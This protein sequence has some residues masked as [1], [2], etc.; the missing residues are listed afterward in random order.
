MK[1]WEVYV[2]GNFVMIGE[3]G[4]REE[5]NKTHYLGGLKSIARMQVD[6][7]VSGKTRTSMWRATRLA[8]EIVAS[9]NAALE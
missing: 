9:H 2:G 5:C 8:R 7:F 1:K 3:L 6:R 4:F